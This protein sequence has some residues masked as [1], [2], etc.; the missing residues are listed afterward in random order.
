VRILTLASGTSHSIFAKRFCMYSINNNKFV[1]ISNSVRRLGVVSLVIFFW[2]GQIFRELRSINWIQKGKWTLH[3]DE[4]SKSTRNES[5]PGREL[6]NLY[7]INLL[8]NGNVH[9]C[10]LAAVG[11]DPTVC[12]LSNFH[13]SLPS[14]PPGSLVR[15]LTL[16]KQRERWSLRPPLFGGCSKVFQ[17]ATVGGCSKF[18]YLLV[19]VPPPSIQ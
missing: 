19:G 12:A 10:T 8:S 13:P 9:T 11:S 16:S 4:I 14:P 2:V 15:C 5:L 1:Q 3:R 6:D 17:M 7:S 18:H